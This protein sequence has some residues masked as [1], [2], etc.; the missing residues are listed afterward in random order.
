M[1]WANALRQK[2]LTQEEMKDRVCACVET[3]NPDE[4]GDGSSLPCMSNE[5]DN[6]LTCRTCI[7]CMKREDA[8]KIMNLFN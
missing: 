4:C 1:Y 5:F 8:E 3:G 7:Y 6:N 2:E